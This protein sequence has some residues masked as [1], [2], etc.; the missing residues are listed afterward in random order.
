MS[1]LISFH[2][3]L[4]EQYPIFRVHAYLGCINTKY[5]YTVLCIKMKHMLTLRGILAIIFYKSL[6]S[7]HRRITDFYLV[8]FCHMRPKGLNLCMLYRRK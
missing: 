8:V 2:T 7:N 1:K 3:Q 4:N 5:F 6:K